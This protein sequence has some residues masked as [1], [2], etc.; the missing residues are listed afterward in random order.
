MINTNDM[1]ELYLSVLIV[2]NNNTLEMCQQSKNTYAD[3]E[4]LLKGPVAPM[5]SC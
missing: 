2:I 1:R 4:G 5:G 3:Y